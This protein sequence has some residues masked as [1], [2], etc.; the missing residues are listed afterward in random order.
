MDEVHAILCLQ[1]RGRI[2][3]LFPKDFDFRPR[4][5]TDRRDRF[6]FFRP[7]PH[8]LVVLVADE[9]NLEPAVARLDDAAGIP[10][11][12]AVARFRSLSDSWIGRSFR[13]RQNHS[14]IEPFRA[15]KG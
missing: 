2:P 8:V 5:I 11:A 6:E 15:G 13:P 1:D 14:R 10:I 4:G 7:D 3:L 12:V 9:V